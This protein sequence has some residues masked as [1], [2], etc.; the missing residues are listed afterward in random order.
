MNRNLFHTLVITLTLLQGCAGPAMKS[1]TTK[2]AIDLPSV[3]SSPTH[4]LPAEA[5]SPSLVFNTLAGEIAAQRGKSRQAFDYAYQVALESRDAIAAERATGLGLQANLPQQSLQAAK[6]WIEIEPDSIK[7]HQIAAILNIRQQAIPAAIEHLR[8]VVTLANKQGQ[9]GYLQAAA[10]TEKSVSGPQAL[11]VMQQLVPSDS[12]DPDAFYALALAASRA[13]QMELAGTYVD[14]SLKLKPKSTNALVLKAHTLISVGKRA[15]GVNFLAQAVAQSP[16]N[17]PL[18]NAYARTLVELNEAELALLQYEFL[19]KKQPENADTIYALAILSLQLERLDE[20]KRY[21]EMLVEKHQRYNEACYYLG[22]IAEEQQQ[23]D[24]ALDWY[25]RVE[26]DQQA[27]AQIRIAKILSD[28]G[29]LNAAR[30]TLQR[31]R[32]DQPHNQLKFY[33]IEAELLRENQLF[34]AAHRV[35][36]K[37]LDEFIDHA[38]LLYARGLN[39]ADMDRVDILENDLRKILATQPNHVD[40]LNALGYTLADKTDRL[41]EAKGYIERA[42]SMKPDSPAILDSMGWVEFR[43]GNLSKARELLE[44]AAELSPDPEIASHLGEVLWQLGESEKAKAVW[45]DANKLY[46]DNRFIPAVKKRLGITD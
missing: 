12:K 13:K 21:L 4:Q 20:A 30:E 44:K 29:D 2:S 43:L 1:P 6:L 10:I 42:L 37:A 22:V 33:L 23:V 36:S 28:Q 34:E 31:L 32:V 9:A 25:S 46:P 8:Q 16:D 3:D 38:E 5:S 39:A 11:A 14:R 26:G 7:A 24:N 17:L 35:Y 40:A 27:D 19:Y 15:D 41:V 18:R 45:D